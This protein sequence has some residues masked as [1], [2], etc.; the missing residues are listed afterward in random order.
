MFMS[1]TG[2]NHIVPCEFGR[3]L[4]VWMKS[5]HVYYCIDPQC[6]PPH[7]PPHPHPPPLPPSQPQQHPMPQIF[8]TWTY[9]F[10]TSLTCSLSVLLFCVYSHQL[11]PHTVEETCIYIYET[12]LLFFSFFLGN[13]TLSYT[14]PGVLSVPLTLWVV[15]SVR[16]DRW[17]F[18]QDQS[19]WVHFGLFASTVLCF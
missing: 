2:H 12:L 8:C 13:T 1:V 5:L 15:S 17:L 11:S 4:S 9:K 18:H 10:I 6:P 16:C 19:C 7:S 14:L 3:Y